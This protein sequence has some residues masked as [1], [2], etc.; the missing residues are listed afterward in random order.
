MAAKTPCGSKVSTVERPA[1]ARQGEGGG[2]ES[3]EADPKG[4]FR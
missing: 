4:A 2:A 1:S 3:T